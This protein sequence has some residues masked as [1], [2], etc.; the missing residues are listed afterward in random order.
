MYYLQLTLLPLLFVVVLT[1]NTYK[2]MKQAWQ[3]S[4]SETQEAYR[5]HRRVYNKD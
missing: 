5:S 1:K 3:W 4:V 2:L